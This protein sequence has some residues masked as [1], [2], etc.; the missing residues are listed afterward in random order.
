MNTRILILAALFATPFVA[1]SQSVGIG[2][3]TPDSSAILDLSST[4]QGVL[5]PRMTDVERDA[6]ID[7]ADGLLVYVTTDS[8]FYCYDG[9]AWGLLNER[10]RE[11]MDADEDTKVMVEASPDEDVIHFDMAGVEYFAMENGRLK[12]FNTGQ[13]VFIGDGAGEHDDHTGNHNVALGDSA[14]AKTINGSLNVAIGSRALFA[15]IAGWGNVAVGYKSMMANVGGSGNDAVGTE[16]LFSNISGSGNSAQG[17]QALYAN[18]SGSYNTAMGHKAMQSNT[19]ASYNAAFGTHAMQKNTTGTW[20]TGIGMR[21]MEQTTTGSYNAALGTRALWQSTTSS[22]NTATGAR[23]ME[24]TTTGGGNTA[25]GHGSLFLNTTG[26]ENAAFGNRAIRNGTTSS[27]NT[28]VGSST[29]LTNTKGNNIT[30]LGYGAD[31]GSDSLENATAIGANAVV[32]KSHSMVLGDSVNVGIGTTM[33]DTTFH[34]VGKVKIE[35]GTQ[36]AGKVLVSDANGMATWSDGALGLIDAD[37]DTKVV[38]EKT[39]DDDVI[40]FDMEGVE[41]FRMDSG[42]L[43]VLNTGRSIFIGDGAG[44]NDDRT[45]N[46]NTVLG[47]SAMFNSTIGHQNVAIGNA[48]LFN[49]TNGEHHTAIGFQ[50]MYSNTTGDWNTAA[51]WQAMYA[52]TGGH[53]NV[54]LG[55]RA[56]FENTTGAYNTA[57]GVRA[58]YYNTTGNYNTASGQS[59]LE[60]NT[61]GFANAG[62][63]YHSLKSNTTGVENTALGANTLTVNTTGVQNTAAGRFAIHLNETGSGNTAYGYAASYEQIKGNFNTA[64]G[65]YSL[66]YADSASF[67]TALGARALEKVTLGGGNTAGGHA[68]L[69]L[70]TSGIENASFGNRAIRNGT[71]GSYNVALGSNTMLAN[72]TGSYNTAIGYNANVGA[73]DLENATAIGSNAVVNTSNSLVLGDSVHVGIGTSSPTTNLHIVG[74]ELITNAG[75]TLLDLYGSNTIGTWLNM[76]NTSPGGAGYNLIS[77]GSA[78]GEGVNKFLIRSETAWFTNGLVPGFQMDSKN[79]IGLGVNNP[80][81]QMSMGEWNNGRPGDSIQLLLSG[82]HNWGTNGGSTTGTYKLKIEGYQNDGPVVYPLHVRD[83]NGLVDFYLRNRIGAGNQPLMHFA[84]HVGIGTE[85][86]ASVITNSKMDVVGGHIAVSNDYGVLTYNAAGTGIGAGFD[87][88]A[89]DDLFLYAGGSNRLTIDDATGDLTLHAGE[90]Y[91]TGGGSWVAI[92]D[93]RMKQDIEPYTDGLAEVIVIEP[94]KFKYNEL[95]GY[96]SD[97]EHIGVLAQELNEVA[98]YMVGTFDKDGEEYM[99]VDNSAMTYMLINATKELK[100]L[101]DQTQEQ[102]SKLEEENAVLKAQMAELIKRVEALEE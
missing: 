92:S 37:D 3:E 70:N 87:T 13:S 57:T 23:S 17:F 69:F 39:A 71:T 79:Q 27:Y 44:L 97:D 20:N 50:A 96:T 60:H 35:D 6:I 25:S 76:A 64:V 93:M 58:M 34:V 80:S 40:R 54:G 38:V 73:S 21:A 52:N 88:G 59:A 4:T 85:T 32:A 9:N 46:M 26:V 89:D 72:T 75:N 62:F 51:G 61:T 94:V 83:E 33:P 78:N 10:T 31:V 56:L 49:N 5:V 12:V 53:N 81:A 29:M 30:V 1:T 11:L 63:G 8:A 41:Y 90:A 42:R 99:Q 36:G 14:L 16:A 86:P 100:A 77:T 98:P 28:A 84:G 19:T 15:D 22:F 2:T 45:D 101:N 55:W 67:N 47:D 74:R 24:N 91:K 66:A 102:L 7:P 68:A 65:W 18:T 82:W 95:S 43:E 48:T